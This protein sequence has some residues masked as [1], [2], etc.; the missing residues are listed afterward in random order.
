MAAVWDR[1]KGTLPQSW[2]LGSALG[3]ACPSLAHQLRPPPW[4][5]LYPGGLIKGTKVPWGAG[6]P[7]L[8]LAVGP[9]L[10]AA[11]TPALNSGN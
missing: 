7:G 6:T 2:S 9:G 11:G 10:A 3:R 1:D 8:S 4:D 5:V